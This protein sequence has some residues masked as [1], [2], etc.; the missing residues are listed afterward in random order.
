MGGSLEV[1]SVYGKWSCF[2]ARLP[3][4]PTEAIEE[5]RLE[6]AEIFNAPQLRVLVVDDIDLN[7]DVAAAMLNLFGIEPDMAQN[8]FEAIQKV[9]EN[10]Y[11]IIFMDHMMPDMDGVEA[12]AQIRAMGGRFAQLPIIALTANVVNDAEQ[13]FLK[14][15]FTGFLP[16]PL[17]LS[18]LAV[19]MKKFT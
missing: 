9:T 17:E 4:I 13:F 11:D 12:T 15:K 8:G 1:E 2:T 14:N 5:P 18:A 6:S 3:Y 7:L 10:D 19:C 16:K